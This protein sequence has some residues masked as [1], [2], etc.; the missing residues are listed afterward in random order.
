ME[1][2]K[3]NNHGR[4]L[5]YLLLGALFLL[6]ACGGDEDPVQVTEDP[7]VE[8]RSPEELLNGVQTAYEA[9][10][11][12]NYLALL[13]PDFS[14]VLHPQTTNLYPELGG[15][16]DF[17]L[18]ERIH[19][20]M[21]SGEAITDPI[22]NPRPI[23]RQVYFNAFRALNAW[24]NSDEPTRFPN[25]VWAPFEVDLII[26]CG[27]EFTTYKAAGN[28]KIYV[29]EYIRMVGGKEV[30]YYKLAGMVDLTES[31]KG[32]ENTPWGLIKVFYR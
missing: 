9:K 13:D 16:L 32:V 22:G 29:R 2:K 28:L 4:M 17:D 7:R 24:K 11:L 6:P 10:D 12:E 23:V 21:F 14:F 15:A 8:P 18:E 27:Q 1:M 20:R 5:A 25:S 3:F 19:Q 31:G 26:D 30:K